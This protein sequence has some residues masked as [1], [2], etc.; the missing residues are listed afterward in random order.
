M[1]PYL[2]ASVFYGA[3]VMV[4]VLALYPFATVLYKYAQNGMSAFNNGSPTA[5]DVQYRVVIYDVLKESATKIG[6]VVLASV[7]ILVVFVVLGLLLRGVC[8]IA[9][10]R[11]P[12]I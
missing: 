2:S 6:E 12:P 3:L 5:S 7:V 9:G 8:W 1:L 11:L 4:V 10:C